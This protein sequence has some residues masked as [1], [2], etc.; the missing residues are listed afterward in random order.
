VTG[1][2]GT[3]KGGRVTKGDVMEALAGGGLPALSKSAAAPAANRIWTQL[4]C[5]QEVTIRSWRE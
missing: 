2:A 4:P 1:L 5:L 3:G